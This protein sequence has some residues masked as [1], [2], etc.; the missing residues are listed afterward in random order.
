MDGGEKEAAQEVP[1]RRRG[2][3]KTIRELMS[4]IKATPVVLVFIA[5]KRAGE[6]ALRQEQEMEK[7][8]IERDEA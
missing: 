8:E 3:P 7:W 2:E 6:R 4:L 1:E 5:A